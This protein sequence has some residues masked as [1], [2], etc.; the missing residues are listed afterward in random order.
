MGGR[1]AAITRVARDQGLRRLQLSFTGFAFAEHATWLAVL[2]YAY[3]RGGVSEAG[4]VAVVQ[5]VPAIVVAPCVAYLGDRYRPD[6]ALALG[7]GAQAVT[8]LAT[9]LAMWADL[10]IAAYAFATV[11]STCVT[12]TRPVMASILPLLSATA[13]DLVAANAMTALAEYAG[14]FAGPLIAGLVLDS[15]SPAVVLALGA[16]ANALGGAAVSG[17]RT[18]RCV[19]ERFDA[20]HVPLDAGSVA[21]EVLGGLRVLRAHA[22]VRVVTGLLVLGALTRGVNDVLVVLF[23]DARLGRG[24]GAAGLLGAAMG[25]GAVVGAIVAT[26]LIGSA[27]MAPYLALSAGLLATPFIVLSD[28]GSIPSAFL[29]FVSFGAGESLLRVTTNVAIQRRAPSAVAA[30]IFGVVEGAQVAAMAVGSIGVTLLVR[31]FELSTALLVLGALIAGAL[32]VGVLR[33]RQLG[34][35]APPPSAA[36]MARLLVDPVLGGLPL[37]AREQLAFAA[38]RL[39]F[40]PDQMV[41][42]EGEPGNHYYLMVAGRVRV[43]IDGRFVTDMEAGESFGE[44][45]LLRDVPRTA[46]VTCVTG[47]EVLAIKRDDFLEAVTG[48]PRSLAAGHA[49]AES[50]LG[51]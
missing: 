36:I 34:G 4:V 10:S 33:F 35:D 2:V 13:G 25:G 12:F 50:M 32:G 23:A 17:K 22:I 37:P 1:A 28:V 42:L 3:E 40:A 14:M 45:A 20:A 51:G 31:W 24:G 30:R 38:R 21:S 16:A 6:R 19:A 47:V 29:L 48:H 9:A 11:A 46:T 5:L 39:D 44:I 15:G 26:G 8:M 49:V 27:R 43:T 41:I 18:R 7:Y